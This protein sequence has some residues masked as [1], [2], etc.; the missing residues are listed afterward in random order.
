MRYVYL[1]C[2]VQSLKSLGA[3]GIWK[4]QIRDAQPVLNQP[5]AETITNLIVNAFFPYF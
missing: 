3:P 2:H 1:W 4:I 5:L